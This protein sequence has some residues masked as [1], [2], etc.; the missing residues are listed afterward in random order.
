MGDSTHDKIDNFFNIVDATLDEAS[1]LINRGQRSHDTIDRAKARAK[2]DQVIDVEVQP[3]AVAKKSRVRII[4]SIDAMSGLPVFVVTD[5]IGRSECSTR[6]L[7][8]A[9]KRTMERP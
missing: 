7:A 4:E 9:V 2:R 5:G 8:E 1:H 3:T 6:D